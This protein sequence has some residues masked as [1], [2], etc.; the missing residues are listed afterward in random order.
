M[1]VEIKEVTTIR[2]LKTFTKFPLS[3]YKGNPYYVPALYADEL[4]T[5]RWDRNPAFEDARARYWLAYRDGKV[6]GRIAAMII[7][8]HEQKWGQ[9]LMRF[10]WIDF[11]DDTEV[12]RALMETVE[13]WAKEEGKEGIHGPLGF[14]DL[15]REGMLVEGFNE[16]TT[17][18][19]IYNYPYYP[20]QLESLGYVKDVDWLDHEF[21]VT[22]RSEEKIKKAAELVT[23]RT[24]LRLFKGT[25]KELLKLAPQIFEV[26]EEAY[27]E[28][29]GTVPLSRKQVR[30]YINTYF[31]FVDL[32]YIP[33]VLDQ[34]D[35]VVAF[36]IT[37][38]SFSRA[39][40][41]CRGYLFPFGFILMLRAIKKNDRADLYLVGVREEYRRT[42]I[43]ALMANQI[44]QTFLK[45]GI[46]L[47]ESNLTLEDNLDILAM[48]KY[49]D[50]RQHKRHRCYIK[51][52][53]ENDAI[54]TN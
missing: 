16:M 38:P 13:Q 25:K 19:T 36:G 4:N 1:T 20:E 11:I 52:F 21:T 54:E 43:T 3:L 28:L 27:N 24:G 2:Q 14:T 46:K 18:A 5:L 32:D 41:K 42:G 17:L 51:R 34:N 31:G 26:I 53:S 45:R 47:V 6:V 39:L 44:L 35:R 9:N 37:F 50:N 22:N 8:K 15:D 49:L 30:A 40:Q 23:K 7:S 10:G 33:I 29:Y 48:W 12:V